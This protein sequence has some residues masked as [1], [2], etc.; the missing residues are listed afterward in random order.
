MPKIL[1]GIIPK[2]GYL[3]YW[4]DTRSACM[5][6]WGAEW[7]GYLFMPFATIELNMDMINDEL[8]SGG[9]CP[10]P[11]CADAR[12]RDDSAGGRGLLDVPTQQP[13]AEQRPEASGNDDTDG[14]QR[15]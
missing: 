14:E 10:C 1:G 11:S 15:G 5:V 7:F 9:Q 12:Q 3:R 6:G 2:L 8:R 4:N 13:D